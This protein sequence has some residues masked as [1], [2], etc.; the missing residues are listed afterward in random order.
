MSNTLRARLFDARIR[1][2]KWPASVRGKIT[3][4]YLKSVTND[5]KE[6]ESW[7]RRPLQ[8]SHL[9]VVLGRLT[10]EAHFVFEPG[11]KVWLVEVA[12]SALLMKLF[13]CWCLER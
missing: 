13:H 11:R 10:E 2:F 3:Y 6:S 4:R 12:D 9:V 8:R 7:S 5:D 1:S